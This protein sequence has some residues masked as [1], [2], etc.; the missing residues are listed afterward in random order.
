MNR[1]NADYHDDPRLETGVEPNPNVSAKIT[2]RQRRINKMGADAV[3]KAIG[4]DEIYTDEEKIP[5]DSEPAQ[6]IAQ[7]IDNSDIQDARIKNRL[8]Q[9]IEDELSGGAISLQEAQGLRHYIDHAE[10]FSDEPT[11]PKDWLE[12]QSNS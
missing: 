8:R 1:Y 7:L 4:K 11:R 3:R 12:S 5:F 9:M 6:K 10:G 2:E